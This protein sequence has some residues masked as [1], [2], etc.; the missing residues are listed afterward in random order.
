MTGLQKDQRFLLDLEHCKTRRSRMLALS[1]K[2]MGTD[3][4]DNVAAAES[5]SD[6]FEAEEL[7]VGALDDAKAAE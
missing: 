2:L 3:K 4:S 1:D 7:L 5:D 6:A